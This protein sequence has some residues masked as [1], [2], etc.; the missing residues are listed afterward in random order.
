MQ[1]LQEKQDTT[2]RTLEEVN[3]GLSRTLKGAREWY[4]WRDNALGD[5]CGTTEL[6]AAGT[7]TD[8]ELLV[9][10]TSGWM[11]AREYVRLLGPRFFITT[12]FHAAACTNATSS[13]LSL[14]Y[15]MLAPTTS[16]TTVGGA[17]SRQATA[18]PFHKNHTMFI[19]RTAAT[20]V[21]QIVSNF[22]NSSTPGCPPNAARPME[23]G[24][25]ICT[26]VELAA[27]TRV[28]SGHDKATRA[29]VG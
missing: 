19:H 26:C 5:C 2:L 24:S 29:A 25:R 28:S 18:V 9:G 11:G 13:V 1:W 15:T 4:D 21:L 8:S 10:S 3:N 14:L 12:P 16:G 22:K 6:R 20:P 7:E 27:V 23:P 17:I